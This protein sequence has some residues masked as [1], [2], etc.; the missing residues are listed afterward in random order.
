MKAI[1]KFAVA[2]ICAVAL[3]AHAAGVAQSE[4]EI[5]MK[6]KDG[7]AFV[8]KNLGISRADQFQAALAKLSAPQQ[9]AIVSAINAF[10]SE[11]AKSAST[12][13]QANE[14]LAKKVFTVNGQVR[15]IKIDSRAS[16]SGSTSAEVCSNDNYADVLAK[17]SGLSFTAAKDAV[18]SGVLSKGNCHEGQGI[19]AIQ[20]PEA[21]ANLIKLADCAKDRNVVALSGSAYDSALGTCLMEAKGETGTLANNVAAI[22]QLQDPKA[23]GFIKVR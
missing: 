23:C 12:S 19:L 5:I 10:K 9:A 16:V 15:V 17:K 3:N 7:K 22:K 4:A 13:A 1:V 11:R 21:A 18:E 8:E 6:T 14:I 2:G 20:N